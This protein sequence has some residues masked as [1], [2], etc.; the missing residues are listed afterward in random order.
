MPLLD[1]DSA[2]IRAGAAELLSR[3]AATRDRAIDALVSL[4]DPAASDPFAALHALDALSRLDSL[5]AAHL[6]TLRKANTKP[7]DPNGPA[8]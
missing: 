8:G 2:E 4:A 1:H 6:Q 7:A 5:D 3:H